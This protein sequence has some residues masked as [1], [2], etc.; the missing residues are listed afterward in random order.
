MRISRFNTGSLTTEFDIVDNLNNFDASISDRG[1]PIFERNQPNE[2]D[3]DRA[4]HNQHN[5]ECNE[6]GIE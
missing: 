1:T 3:N 6:Y 5:N 2:N 4:P